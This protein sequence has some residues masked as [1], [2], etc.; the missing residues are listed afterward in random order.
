VISNFRVE[1]NKKF[2]ADAEVNREEVNVVN[3]E[4]SDIEAGFISSYL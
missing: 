2:S 3:N 4:A 1:R